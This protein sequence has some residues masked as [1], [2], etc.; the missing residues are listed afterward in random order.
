M[1][2]L[3]GIAQKIEGIKISIKGIEIQL[4]EILKFEEGSNIE[5][6]FVIIFKR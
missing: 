3:F 6:R 2:K 5:N 1:L 4:I